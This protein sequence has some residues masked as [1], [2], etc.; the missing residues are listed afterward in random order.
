MCAHGDEEMNSTRDHFRREKDKAMI[1]STAQ[2][3]FNTL[4]ELEGGRLLYEKR[5][6]W[7]LLQNAVDVAKSSGVD[8]I[9]TLDE[10]SLTFNHNG[11]PFNMKEIAHLIYHGSTKIDD[12][13]KTRFG[14]GFITTHL[15]SRKPYVK[16]ILGTGEKFRFELNREGKTQ[17]QLEMNM[18]GIEQE[19]I[20]SL[21]TET[22]LAKGVTV[23]YLYPLSSEGKQTAIAGLQALQKNIAFVLALNDDLSSVTVI[24]KNEKTIWSKR[25]ELKSVDERITIVAVQSISGEQRRDYLVALANEGRVQAALLLSRDDT[26]YHVETMKGVPKL[27]Y[28]FPLATTEDFPLA[29]VIN[30]TAFVPQE[31]RNGLL[32]GPYRNDVNLHNKE[33][34]EKA[35][36]LFQGLVEWAVSLKCHGLN[37]L[38]KIERLPEKEWL[39]SEW[40]KELLA[41]TITTMEKLPLVETGSDDEGKPILVSPQSAYIPYDEDA[42]VLHEI[43]EL[44]SALYR[45]KL[46]TPSTERDWGTI[47]SLWGSYLGIETTAMSEALTLRKF[48]HIISN[49]S[50]LENLGQKL[51]GDPKPEPIKWLNRLLNLVHENEVEL[52][53]ILDLVPCQQGIFRKTTDL[54]RD[55]NIDETLKDVSSLLDIE[56]RDQLCNTGVSNRIQESLSDYSEERLLSETVSRVKKRSVSRDEYSKKEY[57][58]GNVAL[59]S[60]LAKKEKYEVLS[61]NFPVINHQRDLEEPEFISHLLQERHLLRPVS[62]WEEEAKNHADIFPRK[63]ILSEVYNTERMN[64]ENWQNLVKSGLLTSGVFVMQKLILDDLA[65]RKLLAHGELDEQKEH[66]TNNEIELV[67][68]AFLEDKDWGIID[69]VRRSKQMATKFL[70]F[71]LEYVVNEDRSW[72]DPKSVLCSCEEQGTNHEIYPSKWLYVLRARE[73]VPISKNKDEQPSTENLAPFFQKNQDLLDHLTRD[74]PSLLLSVLGVSPSQILMGSQSPEDR[75]ELDKAFLKLLLATKSDFHELNKIAQVYQNPSLKAKLEEAYGLQK[76]V[77]RNQIIGRNVEK[78]LRRLLQESLSEDKFKVYRIVKGADI[79]IDVDLEFDL[80]D[81]NFQPVAIETLVEG[82]KFRIEVK[83]THLNYVRITMPQ[84]EEAVKKSDSFLLCVVELPSGYE[85]L[86]EEEAE[87]WVKENARFV[88]RI[89]SEIEDKFNEA[90]DFRNKQEEIKS[91]P[92]GNVSIDTSDVQIRLRLGKKLWTEESTLI[93]SFDQLIDFLRGVRLKPA[94][95]HVVE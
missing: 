64:S 84:A 55:D 59:F 39:D 56:I 8:C 37:Q 86:P 81:Q 91:T 7:E 43:S 6:P 36:D 32:L 67:S 22:I 77:I 2:S 70:R 9:F 23:E 41:K 72:I 60:W 48:A 47:L 53:P 20:E 12:P 69:R 94:R 21:T 24:Q 87:K 44:A 71:L 58:Q 40:L 15:L 90:Q 75:F 25:E 14:T 33:L 88:P 13:N 57:I 27:F 89:G 83:S 4:R 79:G 73:W 51:E 52:L 45:G 68:I 28:G 5:W 18:E 85:S 66:G 63:M 1:E 65:I 16:G 34:V 80:V 11:N 42:E 46:P 10:N 17:N 19:F 93:M 50:S 54:F 78:L 76:K 82:K 61:D 30:S 38:A 26:E 3:I 49:F 29:A 74:K 62:V 95:D 35:V 31:R 92:A